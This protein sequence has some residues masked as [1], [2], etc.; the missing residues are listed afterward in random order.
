[1]AGYQAGRSWG[2]SNLPPRNEKN[3]NL[4]AMKPK[5]A[6]IIIVNK[7]SFLNTSKVV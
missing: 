5:I 1:M 4:K 3:S 7:I 6:Y 2:V